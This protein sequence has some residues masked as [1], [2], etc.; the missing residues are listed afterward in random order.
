M[1]VEEKVSML[2]LRRQIERSRAGLAAMP[3]GPVY[4]DVRDGNDKADC[5]IGPPVRP[6]P[7]PSRQ[8]VAGSCIL[9]PSTHLLT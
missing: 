5:E 1:A 8:P 2:E 7:A 6:R 3:D 9:T 4:G